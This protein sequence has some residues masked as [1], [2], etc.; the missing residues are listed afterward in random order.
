MK[1]YYFDASLSQ[2]KKCNEKCQEC[3]F[4][5]DFCSLCNDGYYKI[6]DQEYN[7]SKLP[8]ADN[9]ALDSITNEWRKCDERCK[10]CYKQ[11]RSI[12]DHQC[13]L[14]N[15]NYYPYKIEYENYENKLLNIT[16]FNCYTISEVKND[17]INYFLNSNNFFEK[18]DDS[19][20]ECEIK[21]NLCITCNPNYYNILGNKNG[22]CF[23]EPFEGY[24]LINVE[25][26]IFFKKCFHLCKFCTQITESFF[27]QKCKECDEIDYTLDL[28]SYQKSFC[29][30]KDK[31]NSSFINEQSKWYIEDFEG[32]E[33][34]ER[35]NENIIID[36]E[37]ILNNRKYKD[38]IYNNVAKDD[39][40]PLDKPYIIY[41]IRQCVSSCN[42]SN[43]IEHGIFMTKQLYFY[44]NICYDE[45][46]Y[47][48]IK[49]DIKFECIEI[50]LNETINN[51]ISINLFLEMNEENIIN[52][53]SKYANN[54][55]SITRTNDFNNYFYNQT[56]NDSFKLQLKMPIFDFSE[57]IELLKIN[58][59]LD[60]E[61]DIFIG[62]MEYNT[63]INR[64]GKY[65]PYSSPVNSTTYQFFI[66]NGTILNFSVCKNINITTQKNV[67]RNKFNKDINIINDIKNNSSKFNDYCV[68]FSLNKKDLTV[69]DRQ[70]LVRKIVKPCDENC[71]YKDFNA[72]TNYSTCICPISFPD[73]KNNL[74]HIINEKIK[75]NE[76]AK[77]FYELLEKGNWKYLKCMK[78]IDNWK[79]LKCP[80]SFFICLIS[81]ILLLISSVCYCRKSKI[82]NI[83]E[84]NTDN[85]K[86][87]IIDF[88]VIVNEISNER[89]EKNK[90]NIIDD[91][92]TEYNNENQ[93]NNKISNKNNIF[94]RGF[95]DYFKD[96]FLY[97]I[98]KEDKILIALFFI[99]L[100]H[101]YFFLIYYYLLINI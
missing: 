44:N 10:K 86:T 45:C 78:Y 75:E 96:K 53:L 26:E 92:G 56:T 16:G 34:F 37:R 85:E 12:K 41:S 40:C 20:F 83:S 49:N 32:I 22:T 1:N 52:Y 36:Y 3:E 8:P 50:N 101:S 91:K 76:V 42:S 79:S 4:G 71:E 39:K 2:F 60:N 61:T 6:E 38:I 35:K 9:Y 11:T 48:S 82:E 13:L 55:V 54:S 87:Q 95:C 74:Q 23:K 15:D 67:D 58:Y 99:I 46:P 47:G 64:D 100:L 66:N 72:S 24:G 31:S 63:Q 21:N 17:N 30:P 33:E 88:K 43:L 51:S 81:F 97:G 59:K 65:I 94:C 62:V 5:V 69:Y 14:C 29:I 98:F 93:N 27:Y 70:L 77:S 19:C 57:C 80:I 84:N 73:H 28:Y 25:G 89:D 90:N 68:P 7:C 18:C